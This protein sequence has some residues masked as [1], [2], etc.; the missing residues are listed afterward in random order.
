MFRLPFLRKPEHEEPLVLAMTG[1]RLGD[2]VIFAGE[3]LDLLLPLA[4]RAGMS[5]EVVVVSREGP[6]LAAAAERHGLLVTTATLPASRPFDLAVVQVA[7]E[8]TGSLTPLLAS[9]RAGGRVIVVDRSG[10]H[11]LLARLRRSP[12]GEESNTPIVQALARAGWSRARGIGR[13]EGFTFVEAFH[14]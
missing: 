9:V 3:N 6:R 8:W 10:P 11:G 1:V 4:A 2:R 12:A 13:R 5:G 14:P 7:A